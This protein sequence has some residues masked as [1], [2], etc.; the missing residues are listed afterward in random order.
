MMLD[1]AMNGVVFLAYV[2]QAFVPTLS[3]GDIVVM[4]NLQAHKAAGV[5]EAIESAGAEL[6]F[7]PSYSPDF[8]PIEMA[9]SKFKAMLLAKAER[10]IDA[11]WDTVGDLI[12]QFEPQ[13][14]AN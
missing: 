7:L 2:G 3:R 8:N 5:R 9:F 10:T 11:L 14:C 12:D 1:E 13:D 4:D 6:R